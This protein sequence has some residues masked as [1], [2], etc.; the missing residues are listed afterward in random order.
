LS[1]ALQLPGRLASRS[2]RLAL[3]PQLMR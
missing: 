2:Q 3:F 1:S